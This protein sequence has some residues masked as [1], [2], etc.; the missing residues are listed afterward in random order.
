MIGIFLCIGLIGLAWA[1]DAA[2]STFEAGPGSWAGFR[3]NWKYS[4]SMEVSR[5]RKIETFNPNIWQRAKISYRMIPPS[6]CRRVQCAGDN[7]ASVRW[8]RGRVEK[9]QSEQAANQNEA[10]A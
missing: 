7:P 9:S 1:I 3:E 2:C 5:N 4:K 6:R 8:Y 10:K